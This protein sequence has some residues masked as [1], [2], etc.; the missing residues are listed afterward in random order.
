MLTYE[1]DIAQVRVFA[2]NQTT[3]TPLESQLLDEIDNL[4][5]TIEELQGN[6]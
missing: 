4:I 1:Y 3:L 6:V 2:E 5:E